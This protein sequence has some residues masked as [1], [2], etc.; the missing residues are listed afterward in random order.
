MA[1]QLADILQH[2]FH[3]HKDWQKDGTSIRVRSGEE[4]FIDGVS[5][6]LSQVNITLFRPTRV[7][8]QAVPIANLRIGRRYIAG[9]SKAELPVVLQGPIFTSIRNHPPGEA[10]YRND[11]DPFRKGVAAFLSG[12]WT[13]R[14]RI[15]YLSRLQQTL[16]QNDDVIKATTQRFRNHIACVNPQFFATMANGQ[17]TLN[18]FISILR[19][20]DGND[21][22]AG[23]YLLILDRFK[24]GSSR[25]NFQPEAY[26][27]QSGN[28]GTRI[29]SH[30]STANGN[31]KGQE[32]HQAMRESQR[33]RW[34]KLA[35]HDRDEGGSAEVGKAMRD[36]M[37][38]TF[39]MIFGTM[40]ARV[41]APTL[42]NTSM[43]GADAVLDYDDQ[44][45][46]KLFTDIA[47]EAFGKIGFTLPSV[48]SRRPPFGLHQY[49]LNYTIPLGGES[50]DVYD[51]VLWCRQDVGKAF[52]FHRSPL[53]LRKDLHVFQMNYSNHDKRNLPLIIQPTAPEIKDMGIS[54]GDEY[55]PVWEIQKPGHDRHH[56]PF[57]RLC[58]MGP[59]DN[60][61]YA[62]R[63]GFK[64][65]WRTKKGIWQT[66]Y[67]QRDAR[68]RF[69][70][71]CVAP[72]ALLDYS[73]GVGVYCYFM[74]TRFPNAQ[75]W[76]ADFGIAK[77][78]MA[79][80][81]NFN[82]RIIVAHVAGACE[83]LVGPKLELEV[84]RRWMVRTGLQNVNGPW[85]SF[86]FGWVSDPS[87][88]KDG[89]V[90]AATS[91][92]PYKQRKK[93]NYCYLG[94]RVCYSR[95]LSDGPEY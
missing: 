70:E 77:L 52:V 80:L 72:G 86:D 62:N 90:G 45:M 88:W 43:L 94:E 65:M 63:V 73:L 59:W 4:G 47:S 81:D 75:D 16:I 42:R 9:D 57:F 54:P 21:V 15:P 27:G 12:V 30:I 48:R 8:I 60:W 56:T 53:K 33:W 2:T 23:I 3:C 28:I 84:C 6:D 87:C 49:G 95:Y 10:S 39:M 13:N 29:K 46:A 55:H 22:D 50:A 14:G 1:L 67:L 17:S 71:N 41:M 20:A 5:P 76:S 83:K 7:T 25:A 34:L 69:V 66:K 64:L 40:S 31:Q 51:R 36:V 85:M 74:R 91:T 78:V 11:A 58:E 37:E 93:C 61:F 44:E 35:K 92:R 38:T 26:V 68:L 18:D 19:T 89:K 32:V 82:Q 79:T 24:P